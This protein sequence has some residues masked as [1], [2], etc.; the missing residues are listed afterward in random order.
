[1]ILVYSI[2]MLFFSWVTAIQYIKKSKKNE[3]I[4]EFTVENKNRLIIWCF[5]IFNVMLI[6][7]TIQ[8]Y[9]YLSSIFGT[10]MSGIVDGLQNYVDLSEYRNE[11]LMI[12]N[13]GIVAFKVYMIPAKI[14]KYILQVVFGTLSVIVFYVKNCL[15]KLIKIP[16]SLRNILFL[17]CGLDIVYI[18]VA[19]F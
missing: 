8:C 3:L 16:K 17:L 2:F 9:S 19:I 12:L 18:L 13:G 7:S 1:M 15:K 6:I 11:S 10:D 4:N 5:V 14:L